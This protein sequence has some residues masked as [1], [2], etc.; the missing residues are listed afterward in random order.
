MMFTFSVLGWKYILGVN[1]VQKFKIVN[2]NWNLVY[3]AYFEYVQVDSDIH[4]FWF[5]H[6]FASFVQNTH[7][8][9]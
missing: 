2:L 9:I 1:L 7:L 5:R 4:F 6:F 3:L 8:A